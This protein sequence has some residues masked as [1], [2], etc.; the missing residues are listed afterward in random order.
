MVTKEKKSELV[1]K[2]GGS[3]KNTG[4]SEAQIA[5]LTEHINDL[6]TH[7]KTHAKD[8]HS[9]FGLLKLVGK[10][11]RLLNYLTKTD[12]NRYRA[13]IKELGIRK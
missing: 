7:L 10:R 2:Y 11:K 3:A 12:I 9:R 8:N 4:S 6:T 13:I 1:A 5:L